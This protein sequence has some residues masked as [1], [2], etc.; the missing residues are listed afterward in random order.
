MPAELSLC[1]DSATFTSRRT[2]AAISLDN[3]GK[4]VSLV[5]RAAG[6]LLA[7]FPLGAKR[8]LR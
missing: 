1:F 8:K 4:I 5:L 7:S 6:S 3:G 2:P